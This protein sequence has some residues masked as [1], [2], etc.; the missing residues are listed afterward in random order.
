MLWIDTLL[1]AQSL[2]MDIKNS[3]FGRWV[4]IKDKYIVSNEIFIQIH[5]QKQIDL[6]S[7]FPPSTGATIPLLVKVT[8]EG[9]TIRNEDGSV[10]GYPP[11]N[12]GASA[13]CGRSRGRSNC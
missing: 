8:V 7:T 13:A 11:Q 10:T 2:H 4:A 9:D 1:P 6:S 5:K 12:P 3:F